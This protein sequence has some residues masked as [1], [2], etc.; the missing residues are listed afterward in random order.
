M[1]EL[2]KRAVISQLCTQWNKETEETFN[3]NQLFETLT[4]FLDILDTINYVVCYWQS[5]S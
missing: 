3:M 5:M 2:Q 1:K 4:F